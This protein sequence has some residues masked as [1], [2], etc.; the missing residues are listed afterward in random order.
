MK[1][2]KLVFRSLIHY[3]RTNIGVLLGTM[4][5]TA[6]FVG[7]LLTGDSARG[8]LRRIVYERLGKIEFALHTSNRFFR[9]RLAQDLSD[10]LDVHIAPAIQLR[11]I[12]GNSEKK[13]RASNV[14]V[15]GIDRGFWQFR[16]Q[17]EAL[18]DIEQNHAIIN[19]TLAARIALG[20]GDEFILRVPKVRLMPEDA[21]LSADTAS[22]V[23]LRLKVDAVVSDDQLGR[24]SLQSN[25]VSPANVFVSLQQLAEEIEQPGLANTLLAAGGTEKKLTTDQLNVSLRT[26][27][28]SGDA[29]FELHTLSEQNILELRSR[30][31]FIEPAI[32]QA[33][34]TA[35]DHGQ[36]ILTYFVNGIHSR[37][38]T[39]PYS[40]VSAPGS[41]VVP[42][43]VAND[44]IIVTKWLADDL[45]VFPGDTISLSYLLPV[46]GGRLE[47][48][49]TSFTVHSVVPNIKSE[50]LRELMPPFPGIAEV[51]S[52][53]DWEPGIPIDLDLIRVK[54][55]DY[56]D[57]FR[58]TPKAFVT[59]ETAQQM[60]KNRFGGLTAV[61]FQDTGLTSDKLDRLILEN[62][63]PSS[64]GLSFEPVLQQGIRAGKG[65]VDF[66]QLFLGLSM[67]IIVSS[68]L[69]TSLLFA[70]NI[71]QRS[72]ET[73]TLL[74]LGIPPSMVRTLF[75]VEGF[76]I[77]IA[78]CTAG[79][80]LGI[81]YNRV[82]LFGLNT[83]W[84]G[85][86]GMATTLSPSISLPSLLIGFLSSMLL[87]MLVLWITVKRLFKKSL[88]ALRG[89]LV[90]TDNVRRRRALSISLFLAALTLCTVIVLISLSVSGS[91]QY[92]PGHFF[93]AGL[94]MLMSSMGF[95]NA[96]L[97]KRYK[98]ATSSHVTLRWLALRS[99]S[100]NRWRSIATAGILAC[101]IFIVVAVGS[102][103]PS[104]FT[105][106]DVRESGT[107]GF[108][109]FGK[110][111]L[112]I[113]HDLNT[114]NGRKHYRLD[115]DNA[116][117]IR[118][119]QFRLH[120]GD[121]ASCLNLN[122]IEN[123]GILGVQPH[124]LADRHSFSFAKTL[125]EEAGV[126][127]WLLLDR[128][129]DDNTVPA[130]AD[131]TVITWGLKKS[132]GDTLDYVAEDGE[133]VELKLVAGLENSIFQ[134][135]IL[136]SEQALL[137]H[138]PSTSGSHVFLVD[139]PRERTQETS[140][141]LNQTF[142]NLGIVVTT[143]TQ[144]LSRFNRVS[145]TYLAIFLFLG[146]LGLILGTFGLGIMVYRNILA[147]RRELGIMRAV[148][149]TRGKINQLIFL[150]HTLVLGLGIG[151]GSIA[152]FIATLPYLVAPA[153]T[154][155]LGLIATILTIL[156]LNGGLWI[157][158]SS[159]LATRGNLI[160]ALRS[161]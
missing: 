117:T 20:A 66:G 45:D 154:F 27:W 11:G 80:V 50:V 106:S 92:N 109:L 123:P 95:L 7:A 51:D 26:V 101:G 56:W 124:M 85:A 59:L 111:T 71:E 70:L 90:S 69:L 149:Y 42:D 160:T 33:A 1:P 127:P 116:E 104:Y 131:Q 78:G 161:E 128:H 5:S 23:S 148:G 75:L 47:E 22:T 54:D 3:R 68:L 48:R 126:N 158:L 82:V 30:R 36:G 86:V 53:R 108:T 103:R 129:I 88:T 61:R 152:A 102:N 64:L 97:L 37:S 65:A 41:T 21:P 157:F 113:L 132:L 133:A 60:W 100:Q 120:E 14:Q 8:S 137:N 145:D 19:S 35:L 17:P 81:F 93:I 135:Y 144:R 153:S 118:F 105:E 141:S 89:S 112:P 15:L 83:V 38:G 62:L 46:Q 24:Y 121:D 12:A 44:E 29:G 57:L 52:C 58:G 122:H 74:S 155:P 2:L 94:L 125:Y 138:F 49:K 55:Q 84:Q 114:A 87:V 98:K 136:I 18:P 67:F 6:I 4:V 115:L 96:V 31:I 146:G 110:T 130:I 151:S 91:I 140:E 10:S 139:S 119:V 142:R 73:G 79:T 143:T 9:S 16:K 99:F 150:E 32:E 13:L 134:G 107:G 156:A 39:T 28:T 43:S 159:L 63:H 77:A 147:R 25:Q 40:F 72:E 34:F 76:F